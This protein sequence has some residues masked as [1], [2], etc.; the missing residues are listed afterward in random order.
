MIDCIHDTIGTNGGIELMIAEDATQ[1]TRLD[2]DIGS[3]RRRIRIRGEVQ[4]G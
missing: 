2:A 3:G 1:A 4:Q